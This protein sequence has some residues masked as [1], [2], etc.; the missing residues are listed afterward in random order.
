MLIT[1]VLRVS[2][3]ARYGDACGCG[4]VWPCPYE[5]RHQEYIRVGRF[6]YLLEGIEYAQAIAA[7]GV[8]ARLIS[9]IVPTQP[10][11]RDYPAKSGAKPTTIKSDGK[12]VGVPSPREAV[13]FVAPAS[14]CNVE[15]DPASAVLRLPHLEGMTE[16]Q[17]ALVTLINAACGVTDWEAKQLLFA[18][19]CEQVG[20]EVHW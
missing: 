10:F 2:V 4:G 12:G 6:A 16:Q 8:S 13:T 15:I 14:T 7:R 3:Y 9:H 17:H 18:K 19:L 11:V 1:Q 5:S 20:V